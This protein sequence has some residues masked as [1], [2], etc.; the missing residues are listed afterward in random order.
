MRK[1]TPKQTQASRTNGG[2]S[3]GPK[4]VRG[5]EQVR[6][7]AL[8]DGLFSKDLVIESLGERKEDLERLKKKMWDY[9]QPANACTEMLVANIVEDRWRQ[10]RVRRAESADLKNRLDTS[11]IRDDLRRRD[12]I[13][14]FKASFFDLLRKYV[15]AAS[16]QPSQDTS[17]ITAKLEEVRQRLAGTPLGV[18]FLIRQ[19]EGVEFQARVKGQLSPDSVATTLACCGFGNELGQVCVQVNLIAIMTFRKTPQP[20]ANK[21]DSESQD[22]LM[23]LVQALK[24]AADNARKKATPETQ[25]SKSDEN[26]GSSAEQE[27]AQAEK[28]GKEATGEEGPKLDKSMYTQVLVGAIRSAIRWLRIRKE[29]LEYAEKSEAKTRAVA[30][31]FPA[32][33]FDRFLRAET[34]LD[35]RIHRALEVLLG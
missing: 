10:Q 29:S 24:S 26:A 14:P 11:W 33:A 19:M 9:F 17:P 12:E 6:L 35:D 4:S 16:S 1:N 20:S 32:E 31:I 18:D 25:N 13:E 27:R 7:N 5:K 22:E 8:K 28:T 2:K 30:S 15:M 21:G 3:N 34:T 23:R